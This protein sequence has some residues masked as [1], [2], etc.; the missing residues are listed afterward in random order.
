MTPPL[1]RFLRYVSFDTQS[2]ATTGAHPSTPGQLVLAREVADELRALGA[3]DVRV[4]D[5]GYAYATLPATPG[6]EEEPALG[7]LA[8]LDTAPDAPGAGVRPRVVRYDGGFLPL[9]NSGRALDP[10]ADPSLARLAGRTLVVTDGTTLLGA[11]D[12]AGVAILV[13]AAERLLAPDAP[14]HG[15][16]RLAFTP[17]EEI[18]E[19]TRGFDLDGF[20]ATAAFTVDGGDPAAL[21]C[22]NFNAAQAVFSVRGVPAHPGTAKGAMVNAIKVA[23]EALAALPPDECPEKTEGREGFYHPDEISG[24]VASA[25]LALLVRDHD[26]AN[27][28]RRKEE[29]RHIARDLDAKYGAGTVALELRDQ[30]RNMEDA[31]RGR[32]GLVRAALDAIRAAG[33][34]PYLKPVRGGTDGAHLTERGLPCP[35]LGTGGRRAHAETEFLVVE[36]MEAAVQIVLRLACNPAAR[37]ARADA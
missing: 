20:G 4:S 29:L 1:D 19:G 16:V 12:K 28:E 5:D 35:N 18:N 24:T 7:F 27:F 11:D 37:S 8:H 25:R 17:D 10:A 6:R 13:A 15:A 2:D 33:L 9:G 23:T 3:R 31:L 21:Q 34:E 36:E 26:A 30:Y 32:P 22:S 14:A